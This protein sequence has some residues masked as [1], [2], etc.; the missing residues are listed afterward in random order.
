MIGIQYS[1]GDYQPLFFQE[2]RAEHLLRKLIMGRSEK[3]RVFDSSL[4]VF[5]SWLGGWGAGGE[6]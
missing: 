3:M 1:N 6:N 5:W 4:Q 2:R